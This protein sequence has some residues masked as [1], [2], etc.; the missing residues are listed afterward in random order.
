MDT[1]CEIQVMRQFQ[2][3][4]KKSCEVRFSLAGYRTSI[5][6]AKDISRMF[7][8]VKDFYEVITC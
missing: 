1:D 5:A 4:G 3:T 6:Q 8:I 7:R 2:Q